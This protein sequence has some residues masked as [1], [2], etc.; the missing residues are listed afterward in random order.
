MPVFLTFFPNAERARVRRH[1]SMALS[2]Y[3]RRCRSQ[4]ALF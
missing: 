2:R 4:L 1:A 3:D